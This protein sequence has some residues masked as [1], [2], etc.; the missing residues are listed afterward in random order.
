MTLGGASFI[1]HW[2]RQ[3]G[4]KVN[5]GTLYPAGDLDTN[6]VVWN[7]E[8]CGNP[9]V[10]VDYLEA[11]ARLIPDATVKKVGNYWTWSVVVH[12]KS[13]TIASALDRSEE[14][15]NAIDRTIDAFNRLAER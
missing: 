9:Q 12:G 10:G 13:P 8:Q 1:L 11:L 4:R 15:L 7:A 14:W 3:N 5:F 2:Y 6:Y